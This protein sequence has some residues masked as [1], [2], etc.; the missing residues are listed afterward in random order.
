MT[1]N[2]GNVNDVGIEDNRRGAANHAT[3]TKASAFVHV[4]E[5]SR[6]RGEA[7]WL[8]AG[9]LAPCLLL[10]CYHHNNHSANPTRLPPRAPP[11]YTEVPLALDVASITESDTLSTYSERPPTTDFLLL[12]P[13]S[14]TAVV[15]TL[16]PV[17]YLTYWTGLQC[18]EA[19]R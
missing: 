11:D 9:S 6:N 2:H 10:G 1:S 14:H 3:E 8:E 16:P 17:F 4:E 13:P 19:L 12:P 15:P 18:S 5:E 7:Q